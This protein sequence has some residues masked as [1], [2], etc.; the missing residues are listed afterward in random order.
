MILS[1]D[2]DKTYTQDPELWGGF[3]KAA[4]DRGHKVICITMRNPDEEITMPCPIIY[5]SRRAKMT[6]AAEIGQAVDVWIDDAPHWLLE[7]SF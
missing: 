4:T 5:T 2:Y 3:I 6:Y 7:D 1:L